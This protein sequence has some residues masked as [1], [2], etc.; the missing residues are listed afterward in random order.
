[1]QSQPDKLDWDFAPAISLL[2]T[3]SLSKLRPISNVPHGTEEDDEAD[4]CEYGLGDFSSLWDYLGRPRTLESEPYDNTTT[5]LQK[6]AFV[7]ELNEG[8]LNK[9][10]RWRDE[11]DGADLEDNAELE[12][13]LSAASLRTR[14]RAARRA[15]AAKRATKLASN[16]PLVS[17]TGTDLESSEELEYLRRSPDRRSI[18]A[19]IIGR[20]RPGTRDAS[21]PP[22]SP[23]PPKSEVRILKRERP[24][25]N[26]FIWQ[27]P[28]ALSPSNRAR[29]S[30]KDG[31][32]PRARKAS[33]ISMLTTRF[34]DERKYL[35]NSGLIEPAFTPLNV[36]D[37]GVHVFID[38]SNIMIGFHDCLKLARGISLWKRIQRVPMSFHNFS[39]VL[40]RGRPAAKR[41]L[42][43]SDRLPVIENA[44]S[45]G[46]ET[47]ILER[48]HKAREPTP[49]KKKF[50]SGA[51]SGLETSGSETNTVTIPEKWVEQ[52]VDEILHL[53]ILESL[54]D[55]DKPGIIVLA[56]GDAAE[57]EYSGGFMRMVERALEKRWMVELVSFKLNTGS[58]YKRK[59]FRSKWGGM[60][61]WIQLD[62]YVEQL[63]DG[64]GS[65]V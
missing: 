6:D 30:P 22:T 31:L 1:M 38:I 65:D 45:I 14:K 12:P 40:E 18:I 50:R 19:D 7:A 8:L 54:V 57:A 32:S 27:S 36:S 24:I 39:L 60:F 43:G 42:V 58:A 44:K 51:G 13:Q 17:D 55:A 46:Y 47:N 63:V 37:T 11:L 15:R 56:T 10:V 33:L 16:F 53:K 48:V 34:P 26:P 52:A 9:G 61:K 49:R 35:A 5:H 4:G 29:I 64:E 2:N 25:S 28:V 23:S 21:S 3:L 41:V 62:D 20:P 59:E